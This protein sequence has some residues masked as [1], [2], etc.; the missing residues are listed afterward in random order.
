MPISVSHLSLLISQDLSEGRRVGRTRLQSY[1]LLEMSNPT[2]LFFFFC[3][4]RQL[5]EKHL[6]L[7]SEMEGRFLSDRVTER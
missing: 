2:K 3:E 1:R 7:L 4:G 5:C 6:L